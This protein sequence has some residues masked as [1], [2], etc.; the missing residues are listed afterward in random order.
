MKVLLKSLFLAITLS[1]IAFSALASD[2]VSI[3]DDTVA[4]ARRCC[5]FQ[6][7]CLSTQTCVTISPA[8]SADK[9]NICQ[10]NKTA[11]E[12]VSGGATDS[13]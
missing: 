12:T 9:A 7:D 11:A 10:K 4:L 5:T 1:I 13:Q 6:V 3:E 8:C 2:G